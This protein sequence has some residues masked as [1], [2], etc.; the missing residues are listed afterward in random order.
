MCIG[1]CTD[2]WLAEEFEGDVKRV[3]GGDGVVDSAG[4][5]EVSAVRLRC[6]V[7]FGFFMVRC[8]GVVG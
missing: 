2:T 8:S 3:E 4:E 1:R 5:E 7:F 6:V